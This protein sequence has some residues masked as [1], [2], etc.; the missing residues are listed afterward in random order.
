M[1]QR[2]VNELHIPGFKAPK[3][4]IEYFREKNRILSRKSNKVT[5]TQSKRTAE[6]TTENGRFVSEIRG[7]RAAL[8][9]SDSCIV[10]ADQSG[11]L[12]QLISGRSLAPAGV[13]TVERLVQS[14]SSTTA[15]LSFH[16]SSPVAA[17]HQ[18]C[19]LCFL[20]HM[21][22]SLQASGT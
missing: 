13:K 2:I 21:A 14:V 20:N 19:L 16:K 22:N 18:N 8:K 5:S 12:K 15:T 10:N 11:F 3:R 17:F 6:K 9:L 7:I 1:A 4:W